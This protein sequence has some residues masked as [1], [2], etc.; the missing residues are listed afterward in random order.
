MPDGVEEGGVSVPA[1]D[2][3][4]AR[5]VTEQPDTAMTVGTVTVSRQIK[6]PFIVLR[7]LPFCLANRHAMRL[8]EQTAIPAVAQL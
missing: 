7:F 1:Q 3:L 8:G 6:D 2:Q 4:F 5:G